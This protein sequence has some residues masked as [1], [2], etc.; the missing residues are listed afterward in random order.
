MMHEMH[1]SVLLAKWY[2]GGYGA[3]LTDFFE[4][5][6]SY[7]LNGGKKLKFVELSIP[8]MSGHINGLAVEVL[9]RLKKYDVKRLS[10]PRAILAP[11]KTLGSWHYIFKFFTECYQYAYLLHDTTQISP[12]TRGSYYWGALAKEPWRLYRL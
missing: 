11:A 10:H 5:F 4:G 12:Y 3:L 7:P 6:S 2:C 9:V 1:H 8:F